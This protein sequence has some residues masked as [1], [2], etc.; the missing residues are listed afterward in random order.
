MKTFAFLLLATATV[1]ASP[2]LALMAQG[3]PAAQG[4]ALVLAPPFGDQIGTILER[5]GL[6]DAYPERAPFGAFVILENA[7]TIDGLYEN[8]AWFVLSGEGILAL[9]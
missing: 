9:C 4:V 5:T 2:V 3:R 6:T 1:V 7:Q 8:G